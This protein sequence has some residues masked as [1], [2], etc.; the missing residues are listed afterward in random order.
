MFAGSDVYIGW[1]NSTPQPDMVPPWVHLNEHEKAHW[2]GAAVYLNGI[3]F[4]DKV[5]DEPIAVVSVPWYRR[6]SLFR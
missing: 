4:P 5:V 1:K 6:L 2:N 3:E